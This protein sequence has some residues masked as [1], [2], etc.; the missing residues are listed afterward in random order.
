MVR[1]LTLSMAAPFVPEKENQN[2]V[3][4]YYKMPIYIPNYYNQ[5]SKIRNL[6]KGSSTN[7]A[8]NNV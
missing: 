8:V 4:K 6:I 7:F 2:K 3:Q 1:L 5:C